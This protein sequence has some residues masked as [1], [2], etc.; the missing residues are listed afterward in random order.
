MNN[1]SMSVLLFLALLALVV[2]SAIFT[3]KESERG[4][5]LKF[6]E[7]VKEDLQPGL[8]FKFPFVHE[9]RLFDGRIRVL[10]FW[11]TRPA[12][13]GAAFW[14]YRNWQRAETENAVFDNYLELELETRNCSIIYNYNPNQQV[15]RG[16]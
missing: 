7:V 1:K 11:C 12:G 5:L 8:Q 4:V 3:V 15:L 2:S 16:G 9:P 6:G 13:P 14:Y 10:E